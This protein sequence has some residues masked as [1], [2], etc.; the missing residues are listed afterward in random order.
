MTHLLLLLAFIA[1]IGITAAWVAESPGTVTIRFLDYQIDTSFAFL[2]LLALLL[3][4]LLSVTYVTLRNFLHTPARM[5]QRRS[6]NQY[7]K[8]LTELTYSVAALAASDTQSAQLHTKKAEKLLGTTPLTLLLSA[9]IARNQG[10]DGKAQV[11]LEKLLDHKETEYLAARSLSEAAGKQQLFPKAL[12]LAERARRLSPRESQSALAVISLHVR[13]GQWQEAL[14]VVQRTLMGR[15]Q[16][17][18]LRGVIHLAQAMAFD[19][20]NQHESTLIAARKSLAYIPDFVPALCLAAHAYAH[21]DQDDKGLKLLLRSWKKVPHPQLAE[22]IRELAGSLTPEKRKKI[23][24]LLDE[25]L[26]DN[27]LV[28]HCSSC[29]A[30]SQHWHTHCPACGS[31]EALK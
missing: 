4:L 7:K 10:D 11:L 22:T 24:H 26:I 25:P 17:R 5:M 28:W 21:N 23:L 15:A 14:Q 9:Q 16:K 29:H 13:L 1:C 31:F 19:N 8:A 30:P 27:A 18:R 20:D 12:S 2:L 6:L 3:A